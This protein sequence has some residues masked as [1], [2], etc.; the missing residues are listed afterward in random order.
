METS[1]LLTEAHLSEF[2]G[3]GSLFDSVWLYL[4]VALIL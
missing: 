1:Y 3:D 2:G 4:Q